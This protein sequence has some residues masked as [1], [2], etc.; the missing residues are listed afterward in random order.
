MKIK[1][2]IVCEVLR[3]VAAT[4]NYLINV[5]YINKI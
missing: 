1:S 3:A 5:G 4:Y 2:V